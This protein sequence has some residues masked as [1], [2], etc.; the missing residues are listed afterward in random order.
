MARFV[1]I[2]P[3]VY[4]G[5]AEYLLRKRHS[6]SQNS[7]KKAQKAQKKPRMDANRH[8][9]NPTQRRKAKTKTRISRKKAQKAQKTEPRMDP[10][11][12]GLQP[13]LKLWRTRRRDRLRINAN[14]KSRKGTDLEMRSLT[15]V[16]RGSIGCARLYL[17]AYIRVHSRFV[18][19]ASASGDFGATTFRGYADW[20]HQQV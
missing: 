8:E 16:R 11:S 4:G 15:E 1:A 2:D 10:P 14:K 18:F 13:S 20:V 12:Q 17:F 3:G 9:K 6:E 7:C 19:A 5:I